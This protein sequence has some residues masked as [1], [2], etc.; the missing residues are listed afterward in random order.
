MTP[1]TRAFARLT[2]SLCFLACQ[3]ASIYV[4]LSGGDIQ[5]AIYLALLAL[6]FKP[7]KDHE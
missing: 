5:K 6:C 3:G 4:V 7:R 2:D 1:T